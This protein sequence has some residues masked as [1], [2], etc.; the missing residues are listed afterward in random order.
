MS[1]STNTDV[2]NDN[3]KKK[4]YDI[5][6]SPRTG[7][8]EAVKRGFSWPGF[9]FNWIWMFNYRVPRS[10]WPAYGWMGFLI[11]AGV[12][13]HTIR[14]FFN[15]PDLPFLLE[16]ALSAPFT[17]LFVIPGLKGNAWLVR[18]LKEEGWQHLGTFQSKS[19]YDAIQESK[20]V[21]DADN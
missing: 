10:G 4:T 7:I 13:I 6:K 2:T 12:V 8:N 18:K 20:L 17:L 14:V 15:W 16:L 21:T 11:A 5:F 3:T 19:A 1:D 9:F